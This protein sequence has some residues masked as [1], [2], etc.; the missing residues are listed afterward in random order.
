M[1]ITNIHLDD[2]FTTGLRGFK[3]VNKKTN[4]FRDEALIKNKKTITQY[5]SYIT[6]K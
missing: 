5:N 2:M 4:S 1:N 3:E 6:R